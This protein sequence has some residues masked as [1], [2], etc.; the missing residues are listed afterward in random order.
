MGDTER[1]RQP[2]G[3]ASTKWRPRRGRHGGLP[4]RACRN[5]MAKALNKKHW[6]YH[7]RDEEGEE[8][9]LPSPSLN[10]PKIWMLAL[11]IVCTVA[12]SWTNEFHPYHALFVKS[13]QLNDRWNRPQIDRVNALLLEVDDA[14]RNMPDDID[15][16]LLKIWLFFQK[17]DLNSAREELQKIDIYDSKLNYLQKHRVLMMRTHLYWAQG[18]IRGSLSCLF[19][20]DPVWYI[21]MLP[22]LWA[23]IFLSVLSLTLY[24]SL[25]MNFFKV[26]G[27]SAILLGT[28]PILYLFIGEVFFAGAPFPVHSGER[29]FSSLF[30]WGLSISTMLLIGLWVAKTTATV[31][32]Y[33]VVKINPKLIVSAIVLSCFFLIFFIFSLNRTNIK[34]IMYAISQSSIV[35]WLYCAF[36][37]LVG[38]IAF[39]VLFISVYNGLRLSMPV[40]L[41]MP[42]ALF[43]YCCVWFPHGLDIG[44]LP[45][46]VGILVFGAALLFYEGSKKWWLT[47]FPFFITR[48]CIHILDLAY[49]LGQL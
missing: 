6:L 45:L 14:L 21:R 47:V 23:A 25:R 15:L 38:T 48:V 46:Y 34:F 37:I 9:P 8:K 31:G 13:R 33:V 32:G 43:Y 4:P 29:A 18:N 5:H 30:G 39:Y 20:L 40:Y 22:Q 11:I 3:V 41:A 42:F 16:K 35:F 28:L 27:I 17:R 7:Y 24:K 26:I 36:S 12:I 19:D 2:Q 44:E 10:A 49:T 1:K